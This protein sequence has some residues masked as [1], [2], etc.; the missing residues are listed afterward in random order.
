MGIQADSA[1]VP[2][3]G[4]KRKFSFLSVNL[5]TSGRKTAFGAVLAAACIFLSSAAARAEPPA[6][7]Q[8]HPGVWKASAGRPER[9]TLLGAAGGT[10]ETDALAAL[11][12]AEFPLPAGEIDVRSADGKTFLRFPLARGERIYGLGLSFQNVDQRGRILTLRVD[13]YGG[14]D[15]GRTHAPVPFYVSSR[16]YGVLVDAARYITVYAG[17]GVRREAKDPPVLRDRNTDKAWEA[18]PYSD[19]VEVLVPAGGADV[20]VFGG[21]TPLNA[22]QR[23]NLMS[24]GGCLPPK[25][26]LGFTQRVPTLYSAEDILK[27][28]DEFEKR[29]FPL[30][31]IGA[32]PGWQSMAYPCTLE[33]DKG[34]FP[35]PAGFVSALGGRG[36]RTN[37][38][39]NPYIAPGSALFPKLNGLA[40][41]HTVW[42]GIVPDLLLDKAVRAFQEHFLKEHIDLGVGGYKIDEVDGFD[43]WLWPD[44]TTFPS[45][46]SAE[47]MRQVYGLLL[48]RYTAGWFKEKDRRTYGL[49]RGTNAWAAP[50]PYVIYNDSYSHREFITA[51]V[52]SSFLG[53]LWTPEVRASKTAEEWVRRMQSVCFSPMAMI[54][55]WADGT[56]PWSFPEVENA[57]RDA[58]GLR[59]R[60][61]PYLY[62]AFAR[63]RFEG[64]PPFRAMSLIEGFDAWAASAGVPGALRD[65][66]LMGDSLLVAPMFAGQ[67]VRKVVLPPGD[68]F[69]FY[70]GD[71]VGGGQTIEVAP[72]LDRIPLFVRDGGIIPLVPFRRHAPA[73]GE[74]LP[75]EV[76]HYGRASGRFDLYDDDGTTFGFERGRRSW[77]ALI[78]DRDAAGNLRA[79]MAAPAP[80]KPFGYARDAAWRFMTRPPHPEP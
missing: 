9:I 64:I 53:V 32:E 65:Q 20:Y 67:A 54:N 69:D 78:V 47:Q 34:R 1:R 62:T 74:T 23:Y 31:F 4:R 38:W 27:E 22:V 37:L 66:Y 10:A 18:Q 45:G 15:N 68:W 76:R 29:G 12:R 77:T 6:W 40:G 73:A 33:W 50:L 63:Y 70:S 36:V 25:W 49:V 75:L 60:L 56:K 58:A 35:D 55:A 5:R 14:S 48:Q 52:N 61:L 24:G 79:S 57:V 26:G 28:A 80:G 51:L 41:S 17:T 3:P 72:G 19:A 21:P 16:G 59:M 11:P 7:T 2:S 8:I 13:H 46:A 30:D 43:S 71:P 44:T 39:L 42:N